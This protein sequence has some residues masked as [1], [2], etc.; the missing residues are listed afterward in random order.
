AGSGLADL[1]QVRLAEGPHRC[2]GRLQVLHEGRWGGVCGLTWALPAARVT[3][4]YLGCGPALGTAQV[5]VG[6]EELTWL[7][8]LRC[9][10]TE[11]N[12]LQC[13]VKLWGAPYCPHAAVTCAQP[14]ES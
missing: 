3:C 8:S 7:E 13:Q 5:S 6:R 12:L 14:G 10:G 1:I 2:A 4:R 11:G 9:N